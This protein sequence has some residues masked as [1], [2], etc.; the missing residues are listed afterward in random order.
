MTHPKTLLDTNAAKKEHDRSKRRQA[1]VALIAGSFIALTGLIYTGLATWLRGCGARRRNPVSGFT[2]GARGSQVA[3]F[4]GTQAAMAAIGISPL[5]L[6]PGAFVIYFEARDGMRASAPEVAELLAQ[7]RGLSFV[8]ES[9]WGPYG[10]SQLG[11]LQ[12]KLIQRLLYRVAC[13][14]RHKSSR[15]L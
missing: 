13:A 10:R 12:G 15:L 9:T 5:I 4:V 3:S 8:Y 11:T 14:T 7:D 2:G 1:V 6:V